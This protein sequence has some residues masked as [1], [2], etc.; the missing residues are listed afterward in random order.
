MQ[1]VASLPPIVQA[2]TNKVDHGERQTGGAQLKSG[3]DR[4]SYCLIP[5]AF[6]GKTPT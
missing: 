5:A 1:V 2:K 3:G 4:L 6:L